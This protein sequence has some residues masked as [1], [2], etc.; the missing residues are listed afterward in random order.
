VRA[1]GFLARLL[2][3]SGTLKP[4]LRAA[5]E[6]EGLVRLEEGL[7]GSVRYTRFRA[8]GRYH[9]GKIT[10][11]RVGLGISRERLVVFSH[12]GRAK[13]I[14]T[15][16]ADPRSSMLD[17]DLDRDDRLAIGVD[18]DRGDVPKVSGRL[19]IMA[20]TPDAPAIVEELRALLG[21]GR[22]ASAVG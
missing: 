14:D 7:T 15:R 22:G 6:A 11:V 21:D 12:S 17:I 20:R 4:E 10:G 19:T 3:G 18:Y 5:L 8:P 16:F 2:L 13:L 1:V 9:H